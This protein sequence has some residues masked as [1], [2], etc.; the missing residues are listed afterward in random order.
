M[1]HSRALLHVLYQ[2]THLFNC[3]LD[4]HHALGDFRVAGFGGRTGDFTLDIN[5]PQITLPAD[6]VAFTYRVGPDDGGWQTLDERP[7]LLVPAEGSDFVVRIA[8]ATG[9][10]DELWQ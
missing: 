10:V 1:H 4:I 5:E 7:L 6:P 3:R 8:P 2:F 9:L